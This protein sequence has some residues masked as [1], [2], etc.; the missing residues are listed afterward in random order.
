MKIIN[1]IKHGLVGTITAFTLLSGQ[2]AL[3][4]EETI[5]K[6][7][8]FESDLIISADKLLIEADIASDL[9][10]AAGEADINS[11]IKGDALV[12]TG[13]AKISR[14]IEGGLMAMAG[15]AIISADIGDGL[16]LFAGRAKIKGAV[17]GDSLGIGGR[18]DF[19]GDVDGDLRAMGGKIVINN[20]INGNVLASA[21]VFVIDDQA[22]ISGKATIGAGT[23]RISGHIKGDLRVG[24]GEVVISGRIDGNAKIAAKTIKILPSARIAGDLVYH[25]PEAIQLSDQ[26]EIGGDVTFMQSRSMMDREGG[27]FALAGATHI[28]LII[29]LVLLATAFVLAIPKLFPALDRQ[30]RGRNLSCV[31][32]GLLVLI[33]GPVLIFL[34]FLSAVGI[35]IAVL[36]VAV[37]FVMVITGQFGSSYVL[38]RRLISWTRHDATRKPLYRVGATALGLSILW[39]LA[40]IPILGAIVIALAT[41]R[42]VGALVFEVVELRARLGQPTPG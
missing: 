27:I 26:A 14:Q 29:G 21:G 2:V 16:S 7:G 37:Y 31:G 30:S 1:A 13:N 36:L 32:L 28:I 3:G 39:F 12:L 38:G 24:A 4:D 34:L 15:R 41:A 11:H 22:T 42:G 23:L 19:L 8:K 35:P 5:V 9:I 17:K 10:A 20:R 40:V 25:S 18:L 33:A 6:K